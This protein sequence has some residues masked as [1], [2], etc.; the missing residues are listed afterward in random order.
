MKQQK[1]IL[2]LLPALTGGGAERTLINLLHKVDYERFAV[3]L[4]L[5]AKAGVYLDQLPKEVKLITLFD[6]VFLVRVLSYLQKKMGLELLFRWPFR[7]KV[8]EQYDVAISFQDSNFTNLLFALPPATKV[9]S[10]VH[11]SYVSNPNYSNSFANLSYWERVKKQRY[12]RLDKLVFVSEDAR[13]EFVTLFGDY[14]HSE[15]IYNVMNTEEIKSKAQAFVPAAKPVFNFFAMGSLLPVKGFEQLLKAV[16]ILHQQGLDCHLQI[17]G[18]GPEKAN[19]LRLT[20]ELALTDKVEL[21]G[22]QK[23]PYPY[24]LHCDAF[25]LSSLSEALPT[26]IAEAMILGKAIVST[27]CSGAGE[28]LGNNQYGLVAEQGAENLANQM[29]HF[30]KNKDQ[31]KNYAKQA[32][33]RAVIFDDNEA[34]KAYYRIFEGTI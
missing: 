32:L 23:N 6:S 10:W 19:L 12:D 15:V 16:N 13:K 9:I 18:S 20:Q 31:V 4:V 5:V 11:S 21:L 3:S 29:A 26:V 1:K 7:L 30:L 34:L 28:L 25:V 22:F 24:L 33:E 14:E 17:A 27:N 2:F 8:K